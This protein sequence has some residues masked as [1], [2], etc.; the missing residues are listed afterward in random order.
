[1]KPLPAP[2]IGI[3]TIRVTTHP[4]AVGV[5]ND[6]SAKKVKAGNVLPNWS[7]IVYPSVRKYELQLSPSDAQE[8][9][10]AVNVFEVVVKLVGLTTVRV[11][12][13]VIDC[14]FTVYLTVIGTSFLEVLWL[15]EVTVT[16]A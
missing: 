2:E 9:P 8:R 10:F 7:L 15:T 11:P 12:F 4:L 6:S 3:V 16:V 1:V 13:H 5:V 14:P